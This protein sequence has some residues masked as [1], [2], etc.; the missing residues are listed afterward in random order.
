MKLFFAFIAPAVVLHVLSSI[1][2]TAHAYD[3]DDFKG[4]F[5]GTD[6]TGIHGDHGIEKEGKMKVWFKTVTTTN[7]GDGGTLEGKFFYEGEHEDDDDIEDIVGV[8]FEGGTFHLIETEQTGTLTGKLKG[9][10][11]DLRLSLVLT[12]PGSGGGD[13]LVASGQLGK[14]Q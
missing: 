13:G 14:K 9:E 7:D 4:K 3:A 6:T 10:G 8:W 2:I 12:E 1:A 11:K 5:V